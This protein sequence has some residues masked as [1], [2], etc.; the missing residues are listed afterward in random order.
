MYSLFD[1]QYL[2]NKITCSY[3]SCAVVCAIVF[4]TDGEGHRGHESFGPRAHCEQKT[5]ATMAER[6]SFEQRK[7]VLNW[8]WRYN[9]NGR[10]SLELSHQHVEQ[11][12]VFRH[13]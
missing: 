10:M 3:N 8:Y 7:A 11:L 1:S 13:G 4:S 2:W 9:H 6:L 12:P 5:A